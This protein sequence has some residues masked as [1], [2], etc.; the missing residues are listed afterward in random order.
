MPSPIVVGDEVYFVS[1]KTGIV[2][3]LDV[4]SGAEI[5][6]ER[7][8]GNFSASPI[9]ADGKLWFANREG[10]VAVLR[11]GR[12]FEKLA[13]FPGR[14]GAFKIRVSRSLESRAPSSAHG[15]APRKLGRSSDSH[16]EGPTSRS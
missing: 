5:W 13:G 8:G 15:T 6:T 1:D 7:I 4:D 16:V 10:E 2:T 3:C 11:P 14:H 9:F 12:K